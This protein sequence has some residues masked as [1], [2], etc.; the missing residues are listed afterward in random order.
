[1]SKLLLEKLSPPSFFTLFLWLFFVLND[2]SHF[3]LKIQP[4]FFSKNKSLSIEGFSVEIVSYH[5]T[6]TFQFHSN[7]KIYKIHQIPK[8]RFL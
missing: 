1:M 6:T 2:F 7:V 5:S 8:K 4:E 3:D